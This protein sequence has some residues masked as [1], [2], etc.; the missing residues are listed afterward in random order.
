M[1]SALLLRD[2]QGDCAHACNVDP[3][4]IMTYT[5]SHLIPLN[6]CPGVRPIGIGIGEVVQIIIE[7]AIMR[8]IKQ[9]LQAALGLFQ[10]CTGQ[11][12]SCKAAVHAI[13]NMFNRKAPK[14]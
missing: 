3:A 12:A 11:D 6:K 7:K 4:S 2:L 1:I 9:D 10:P 8:P 14:Q 5:A 13:S